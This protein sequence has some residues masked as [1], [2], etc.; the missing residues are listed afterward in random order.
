[1]P[2][3]LALVMAGAV[4]ALAACGGSGAASQPAASTSGGGGAASP[5]AAATDQ[6]G[7]G[8]TPATPTEAPAATT[9]EGGTGGGSGDA[10]K[11]LTTDEVAAATGQAGLTAGPI[12]PATL[13]DASSGCAFIG[14]GTIPVV[15]VIILDP[16]NTNS[17]PD[18][19]K[20]LPGT[21]EVPVNGA[22]AMWVPAAGQVLFVYKGSTVV[23]I[24]VIQTASQD[25]KGTAASLAQQVAARL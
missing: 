11:L 8:G 19:M 6:G 24:Q 15:N 22:R 17:N 13:T 16:Q 23:M 5:V 10:C 20:L 14:G 7:G 1:M 4:L 9:S 3:P 21:E 12:A 2:R 25:I 18:D